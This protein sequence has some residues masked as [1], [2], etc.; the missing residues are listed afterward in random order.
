MAPAPESR[1]ELPRTPDDIPEGATLPELQELMTRCKAALSSAE[2]ED[3]LPL[4]GQM[5]RVAASLA[6]TIRKATPPERP[7]PNDN[8]DFQKLG[9]QVAERLHKMIDA[10]TELDGAA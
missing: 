9:A 5:I 7:D 6:E 8:P 4:V 10:V 3:N 1:P 2:A